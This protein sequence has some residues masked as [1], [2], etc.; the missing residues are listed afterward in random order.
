MKTPT[1]NLR[2]FFFCQNPKGKN[3]VFGEEDVDND[4]DRQ[5]HDVDDDEEEEEEETVDYFWFL[6]F[7][8]TYGGCILRSNCH[9][10]GW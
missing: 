8:S 3:S 1:S 7:S 6:I 10:L 2:H 4:D 5:H 9:H